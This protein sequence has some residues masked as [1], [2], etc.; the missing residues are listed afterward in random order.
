MLEHYERTV[1]PAFSCFV[2]PTK[3]WAHIILP[4]GLDNA[5]AI[6]LIRQHIAWRLAERG[7]A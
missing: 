5:V 3:Q 2:E 1:K 7:S 4:R 6:D